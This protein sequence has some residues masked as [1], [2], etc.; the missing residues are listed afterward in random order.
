MVWTFVRGHDRVEV[1]REATEGGA[2]L[3]VSGKHPAAGSTVYPS[4]VALIQQQSQLEATLLDMGWSLVSFEPERRTRQRRAAQRDT[5]DR[6]RWW[7]DPAFRK[8]RE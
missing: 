5:L 6:R 8:S 1:R 4:L 3:V 7:T 2:L